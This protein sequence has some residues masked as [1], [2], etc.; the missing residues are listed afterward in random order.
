MGRKIFIDLDGVVYDTVATIVAIYNFDHIHYKDFKM[1]FPF[2]IKTWD[3]DELDLEPRDYIDKYFNQ[4]RFFDSEYFKWMTG[5]KWIINILHDKLDYKIIFCSSGSYPNLKMK[6]VWID[7]HFPYAD[8]IPVEMPTYEDKSHVDMSGGSIFID[9]VSKNLI[10]SNADIK[11]CFGEQYT[12]NEDWNGIR[13]N[14]WMEIYKYIREL[15][16]R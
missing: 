13:C 14:N 1:V 5:A 11:I 9:D 7:K 6:G 16:G 3:F 2:E 10:T 8:F 12:W 15:E 4:P